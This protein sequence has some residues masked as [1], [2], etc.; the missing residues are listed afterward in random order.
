MKVADGK[1]GDKGGGVQARG[2]LREDG[3]Q[4]GWMG[5]RWLCSGEAVAAAVIRTGTVLD[6]ESR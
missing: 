3:R 2:V 5:E 1:E 4:K 6:G